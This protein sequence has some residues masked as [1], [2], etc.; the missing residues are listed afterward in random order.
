MNNIRKH[1]Q[2]YLIGAIVVAVIAILSMII[3]YTSSRTIPTDTTLTSGVRGTA[4]VNV[5]CIKAP[6]PAQKTAATIS[7]TDANGKSTSTKTNT[8]GKFEIR[9]APGMYTVSATGDSTLVAPTQQVTVA[10]NSYTKI[11]FNFSRSR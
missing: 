4:L 10:K 9:L 7:V 11:T 8:D 6:C 3:A 2:P 1:K 5:T